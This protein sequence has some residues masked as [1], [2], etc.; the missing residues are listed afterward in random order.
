MPVKMASRVV[1]VP[2]VVRPVQPAK[3]VSPLPVAARMMAVQ[4]T[5]RPRRR[6]I[7]LAAAVAVPAVRVLSM[8]R[9]L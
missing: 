9:T 4:V 3:E 5:E 6:H 7:I 1:A 8:Y 2:L